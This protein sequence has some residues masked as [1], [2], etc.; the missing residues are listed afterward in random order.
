[1]TT[2]RYLARLALGLAVL[3]PLLLWIM[4]AQPFGVWTE[5]VVPLSLPLA[6]MMVALLE[7][8]QK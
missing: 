2:R 1:M 6:G 5:I 3:I 4:A 7:G 8:W